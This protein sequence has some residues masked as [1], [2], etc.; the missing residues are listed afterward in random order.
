MHHP[1]TNLLNQSHLIIS[2]QID[3]NTTYATRR[4]Y[5]RKRHSVGRV[6]FSNGECIHHD[7]GYVKEVH[8]LE[9]TGRGGTKSDEDKHMKI[10]GS[11]S[12]TA[13]VVF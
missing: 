8:Y 1:S 6:I 7:K 4:G 5:N 12:C 13:V 3:R 9:C 10:R 11:R 2:F